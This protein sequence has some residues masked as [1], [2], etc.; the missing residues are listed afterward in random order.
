MF[1]PFF[2]YLTERYRKYQQIPIDLKKIAFKNR[3]VYLRIVYWDGTVLGFWEF[4]VNEAN[5]LKIDGTLCSVGNCK[6]KTL[7]DNMIEF[8]KLYDIF[9]W[10]NFKLF[11]CWSYYS[12]PMESISRLTAESTTYFTVWFWAN[13]LNLYL[14]STST[15]VSV[16]CVINSLL[17]KI[18]LILK[19][20]SFIR[21]HFFKIHFTFL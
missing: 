7:V 6:T 5:T 17:F 3:Y 11:R 8:W 16:D 14:S 20:S 13:I 10:E 12:I 1:L 15:V 19:Q 2:I 9:L 18:C 21:T 4:A